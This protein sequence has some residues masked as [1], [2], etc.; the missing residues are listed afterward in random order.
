M[1]N[2]WRL[3]TKTDSKD[4]KK[5]STYCKEES[6]AAVGWSIN[7]DQIKEYNAE[8]FDKIQSIRASI[9]SK[10]I[11]Y[12]VLEEYNLFNIKP[13]KKI[14][15]VETIKRVKPGD[16]IWM[17]DNG[18]Y[19]LGRVN[20]NSNFMYNC[21]KDAL[22]FD[23]ANQ[24]T[25]VKWERIGDESQVP[26]AVATAFIR[27][28]TIQRINKDYMFE[29]AE[30]AFGG[31][32]LVLEHSNR[33]FLQQLFYDCLSP[34]DCEDLVCLY[35]YDKA[36]YIAIPSTNKI[37]TELYECVLVNPINGKLA[38]PQ[39]KKGNKE[40]NIND[41]IELIK[42]H[43]N[44]EVYLFTSEGKVQGDTHIDNIHSISPDELYS[45]AKEKIEGNSCLIPE[46]IVKWYKL[47]HSSE[48]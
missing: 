44:K 30:Y 34:N 35:L 48:K 38:Y 10:D 8:A 32:P 2:V 28:R 24:I 33:E 17:R 6:I 27:G 23:A 7:D 19:Y 31:K 42:D 40:L 15:A 4:G 43:P 47:I 46:G 9:Q 36:N 3:Q 37:A 45:W 18:I 22:D 14:V 25:G 13:G 12:K 21:D 29:Y 20:E 26:G 11:Y 16:Y 39:V 41:Y 1:G 5:I